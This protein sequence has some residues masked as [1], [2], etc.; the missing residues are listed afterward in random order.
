M[1]SWDS[2]PE[3]QRPFQSRLMEVFAGFVEH[4]DAQVGRL[5][6]GLEEMDIRDNTIIFYVFGDN[7]SS[8][9]GQNGT[10]SELLAQN[11]IPNTIE[12]Q[13]AALDEIG[14]LDA[15]GTPKTDN[16]YHAGWAWAGDTPF[17]YTKLVASHFGGTR[18]PL[19][20]SWP[21]GIK[22]DKTPRP[23]F[24]HVNDIAP[25]IY[26][27]L[28]IKPP[29]V[30]DGWKQLP[31]D[32]VSMT[33]AFGDPNA[34]GRKLTQYF[35]NNGSRA[36]YHDGWIAAAFGP[37]IP[38]LPV[39]PGLDTWDANKDRWELYDI[40]N[41]FSEADDLAEKEPRRLDDMK[42]LF[43]TEAEGQPGLSGRSGPVDAAA[44]G[45]PREGPL[46]PLGLRCDDGPPPRVRRPRARAGKQPRRSGTG[47]RRRRFRRHL[48]ARRHRRRP[49]ALY[50]QGQLVYEYNMMMIE[51]YIGRSAGA[52]GGGKHVI[53][54]D[55]S[56]GRPG[57]PADVAIIIDSQEAMRV[58]VKRT[59]AGAFSA[60]ETLDVGVDLG[61]PVSFALLR[62]RA[63]RVQRQ[64][65][66]SHGRP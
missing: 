30:V 25:T 19:V 29:D 44:P 57:G 54:V 66:C 16:M 21:K 2:I 49:D 13:L 24:H 41:D 64:D 46:Q 37:L 8:A 1:A 35:E 23:Q 38:W 6:D 7:G 56:I 47:S 34:P 53:V 32:G 58:A 28:G 39:T 59:V 22:P 18:N 40:R 43:L 10:I 55:T 63:L 65:P 51:R 31:I 42:K 9:E 14:G 62:P 4:V 20:I 45:R 48:R 5:V 12:Q 26:D 60:S 27:I 52:I 3:S 61:S 17:R 36:I 50:G 33:Y 15:L 11:M